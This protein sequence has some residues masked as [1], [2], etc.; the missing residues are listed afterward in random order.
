MIFKNVVTQYAFISN[1]DDNGNYRVAFKGQD[2]DTN[3]AIE[4]AL[5]DFAKE[6]NCVDPDWW[7]SF[8]AESGF[9]GAKCSSSFTTKKGENVEMERPVYNRHAQRLDEVP[10]IANGAIMNIEVEPY[11]CEY[12]KKKGIMF[13]LRSVQ[14][15][16]YQEYVKNPYS[17]VD[18]NMEDE[19]AST[20]SR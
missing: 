15:L 11:Y 5:E 17:D 20:P 2:E 7:G 14:L 19:D 10:A 16:E 8:N 12:K 4:K 6:K 9:Y 13:G 1:P 3:K 18:S